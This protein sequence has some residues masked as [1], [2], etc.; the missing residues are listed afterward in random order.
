MFMLRSRKFQGS[1][2]KWISLGGE[3]AQSDRTSSGRPTVVGRALRFVGGFILGVLAIPVAIG[4]GF[5]L[6]LIVNIQAERHAPPAGPRHAYVISGGDVS[7]A[8]GVTITWRR[9]DEVT[10]QRCRGVCDDLTFGFDDEASAVEVLDAKGGCIVCRRP[11][12]W[13]ARLMGQRE[14]GGWRPRSS[15]IVEGGL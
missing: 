14:E 6:L 3:L 2:A 13:L 8:G 4:A 5:A 7:R 9:R 1:L 15:R 12:S 11:T 10:R